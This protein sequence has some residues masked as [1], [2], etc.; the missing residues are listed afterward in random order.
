MGL[1]V[2]LVLASQNPATPPPTELRLELLTPAGG[3]GSLAAQQWGRWFE[4]AGHTV[5]TR[6]Q[7]V[8]DVAEVS[9]QTR[10]TSRLVT[11]RFVMD[12]A[13]TLRVEGKTFPRGGSASLR[14]ALAD[15]QTF[16]AA[17]Q[18]S[19]QRNWGI[20]REPLTAIG[21]AAAAPATD[22]ATVAELAASMTAH[23]E[24]P[25]R[26]DPILDRTRRLPLSPPLAVGTAAA[27]Q[28]EAVEM[29]WM[30][31]REPNGDVVIAIRPLDPLCW[32]VGWPVPRN[33]RA[34]RPLPGLFKTISLP[35][36]PLPL[37]EF[38][39]RVEEAS[40]TVV[41]GLAGQLRKRGD[42]AGEDVGLQRPQAAAFP[43]VK[44]QLMRR[45]LTVSMRLDDAG[46]GF[47][48]FEPFTPQAAGNSE[49]PAAAE[50]TATPPPAVAEAI[51]R[52]RTAEVAPPKTL[53]P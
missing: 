34:D 48:R 20:A 42:W 51:T 52:F 24:R 23:F 17:G 2:A 46:T 44:R 7:R 19:G 28:L 53:I 31:S 8:G 49:L 36:E 27:W 15:W 41:L 9:E 21:R 37:P 38:L 16:G 26:I 22:A 40:G 11:V 4:A 18:P 5:R 43:I 12:E 1:L 10:R 50:T 3:R 25:V 45:Q 47:L 13:G 35:A 29:G 39:G 6:R 33:I 30:P 32:P 14:K